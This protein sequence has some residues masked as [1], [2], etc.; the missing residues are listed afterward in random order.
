MSIKRNSMLDTTNNS[1]EVSLSGELDVS[2]ADELK[3][4]LHKLVD[5]KNI[6]MRLN[7]ENLDYIDSTGLGVIIGIL[8]R[9]KI[10]SKEVYIEKPKNN[11][12]KIF[13][14]T[15]LDKIFKLEG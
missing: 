1:W 13:S 2:T 11:V 3:K 15:G 7:L 8:K 4:E 12:R 9:L 10:E 6:D 14:I 5:E